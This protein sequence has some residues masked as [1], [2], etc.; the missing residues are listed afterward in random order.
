MTLTLTPELIREI[1]KILKRGNRVELKVEHG[2]PVL[3]EV[4]RKMK[5]RL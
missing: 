4:S 5:Q 3:I 1:E 2:R